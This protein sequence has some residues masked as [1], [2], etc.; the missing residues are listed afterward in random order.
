M[1]R[2]SLAAMANTPTTG[3]GTTFVV[4]DGFEGVGAPSGWSNISGTPDYD[5][6]TTVLADAQSC[7]VGTNGVACVAAVSFTNMAEYWSYWLMRFVGSTP[8]GA[9]NWHTTRPNGGGTPSHTCSLTA[10][11]K[12]SWNPGGSAIAPATAIVIGTTYHVWLYYKAGTGADGLSN[13][14]FSTD[15]V[16]PTSGGTY[17]QTT[18]HTGTNSVGRLDFGNQAA[19]NSFDCIFDNVRVAATQIGDNGT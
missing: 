10:A 9:A 6:T 5:Y 18:V 4:N 17:A 16:R 12:L 8:G 15:G 13:I 2:F 7:F 14:G 1:R 11:L 3:S 19:T